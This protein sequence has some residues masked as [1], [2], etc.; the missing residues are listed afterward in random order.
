VSYLFVM[1]FSILYHVVEKHL[2]CDYSSGECLFRMRNG[3]ELVESIRS[4]AFLRV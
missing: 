4:S 1:F 2:L 3:F